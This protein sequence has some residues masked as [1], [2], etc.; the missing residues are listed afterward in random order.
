VLHTDTPAKSSTLNPRL[1]LA[2]L[3]IYRVMSFTVA[4]ATSE[5]SLRMPLGAGTSGILLHV[6]K[7]GLVMAGTGL[8]FGFVGA[9]LISRAMQSKLYGIRA[10]DW[11]LSARWPRCS[12]AALLACYVPARRASAVDPIMALRQG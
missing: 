7:H 10:M 11:A 4:Q 1:V 2:S 6:L 9:Y 12:G 5:I 3:G 8:T